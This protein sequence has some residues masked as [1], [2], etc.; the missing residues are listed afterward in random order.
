LL[1]SDRAAEESIRARC[2]RQSADRV[3]PS[4]SPAIDAAGQK[5]YFLKPE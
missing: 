5:V 1:V 3:N 4:V 2:G